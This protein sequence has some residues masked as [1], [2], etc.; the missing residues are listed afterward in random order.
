[1]ATIVTRSGKGSPLTNTEVDA[2]FT[3]LNT[4]K[5]ELS[6]A[7]FTGAITT[8]STVDGRDVSTDG[9]K[10]DTVET[11]ADV[12][13]ATNVTAAGALM[14]SEVTNLAQVKAFDSADYATSTQGSTADAALPKSGGAMTGAITTNST[15]DGVDI[16]TRDGVLSTTTTTANAALPKS[17]GAMTGAITTNSTID[18]RDVATDGTKLDGIEASADVTDT[19][20]VVAA[21]SAGTGIGLSA[22]GAISNT[23]PD[24]TVALTGAGTTSVSGTY[25]NFTI[26]GAGT[27][28]TAGSGLSLTGTEFA[29]TAPDQTVALTGS[30]ATSISGTYPNF[31]ITSTNTTYSVGDGGLTQINFT[32][33]DNTKLDGIATNANNYTLPF[34][35]NSTNWNTAYTYSQVGHL[36]LAGG[37]LTG[38]VQIGDTVAQ[39]NYGFLQVNQEANNDESGIGILDST[40]ARSMRLW[41][42]ATSSYINSG[43]GGGGNLVLNEAITVSSAGNLTGV[44]T[45][46]FA[47]NINLANDKKLNIGTSTGDVFNTGSAICIQDTGNSYLQIKTSTTGQSGILL[48]DT[49]DD[50][51]GGMIY[52]NSTNK[53]TFNAANA[54]EL[55]LESGAATFAGTISSG[56]ITATSATLTG[57]SFLTGARLT[58]T[59][60]TDALRL[61][62]TG[63]GVGVNI[64]FSDQKPS[65]DQQGNIT[66]FH[67]DGASYGSGNAFVAS[68]TESTMTFFADGKLMYGEGVYLKPSSGTGAGTRKDANWDTAY[69]WGNHASAGYMTAS[70]TYSTTA[71]ADGS[72]ASAGWVTVATNTSSR[73]H[74]EVIV[75]DSDSGDHA[76]IRIDW[77]RSYF[78]SN[79]SVLQVGG[80]ANRITGVRVLYQTSDN[81]Y[82]VKKLQVYVTAGSTYGVRINTIGSPRGYSAHTVVTPVIQNSIS[83]YAVHGNELTGL[84]S[85]SLAAEEGITAGGTVTCT[86]LQVNLPTN[87]YAEISGA[88]N[89]SGFQQFRIANT[90][91]EGYLSL[92]TALG[93]SKIQAYGANG[94]AD[95]LKIQVGTVSAIDIETDGNMTLG[96]AGKSQLMLGKVGTMNTFRYV[97][98]SSYSGGL[99]TRAFYGLSMLSSSTSTGTIYGVAL[100]TSTSSSRFYPAASNA[101][102]LFRDNSIDCGH[103]S[104]RWDDVY[105]TNGTIQTSDEREKQDIEELTEVEQRVAVR[106]KGLL[107]KFR[108]KDSVEDKGDDARTHFGIIAQDLEAAFV[109]EGLDPSKYAMFIKTEWW[110]GAKTWPAF[111]EELDEEGNVISEGVDSHVEEEH[112]YEDETEAPSDATHHYRLGIRYSELLAFIISAL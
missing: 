66:Y 34:T 70:Q 28:Y 57:D 111:P 89:L 92:G 69:G 97:S 44:G 88:S 110:I 41:C 91:T 31:T 83:G 26:T 45:A 6:G 47:G 56:A 86:D 68:S 15:F 48:G 59:D 36:P 5:A 96:P 18:G 25:P 33:A 104:A 72:V 7:V 77:L 52:L 39:N 79:F 64:N 17:G 19:T 1:M 54:L 84:D 100:P 24:Q 61:R 30:G 67:A 105:A 4:D 87:A 108:W 78:D 40:N 107:R 63:N 10:L 58:I 75:S 29:N 71:T 9:T 50:Y 106:A 98:T 76:F 109:A 2:N 3:N 81:T 37:R 35:D 46:T 74:G 65:P 95:P 85:A 49:D 112:Y 43:D 23:A 55:T 32:S 8:N 22:G 103:P 101:T 13:D 90:H 73:K 62:S 60:D 21:L 38:E 42:D 16:A 14:D 94:S 12:T 102:S 82:G 53:L 20:N 27:T 99:Q 93:V 51:V 80:H 11:N